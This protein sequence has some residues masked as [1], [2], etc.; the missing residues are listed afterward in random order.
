MLIIYIEFGQ[1]PLVRVSHI[2]IIVKEGRWLQG[3]NGVSHWSAAAVL[4]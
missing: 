1:V 3:L 2:I 4:N